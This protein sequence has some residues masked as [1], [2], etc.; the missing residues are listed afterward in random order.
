MITLARVLAAV[1]VTLWGAAAASLPGRHFL[2]LT[3]YR[4]ASALEVELS[5]TVPL[6]RALSE[7][8]GLEHLVSLSEPNRSVIQVTFGQSTPAGKLRTALQRVPSLPA[9]AAMPMLRVLDQRLWLYVLS[10]PSDPA[11]QGRCQPEQVRE[12]LLRQPKIDEVVLI[13]G[14]QRRIEIALDSH[15]L[16]A[17]GLSQWQVAQAIK[18]ASLSLPAG[19]VRD[20]KGEYLIRI[21][22]RRPSIADLQETPI[23]ARP[24]GMVVLLQDLAVI[25][26]TGG[27]M[28]R[29][30]LLVSVQRQATLVSLFRGQ[31]DPTPIVRRIVRR[32][33][34]SCQLRPVTRQGLLPVPTS[35]RPPPAIRQ[36]VRSVPEQWWTEHPDPTMAYYHWLFTRGGSG[37]TLSGPDLAV[38]QR[39]A[40][41]AAALLHKQGLPLQSWAGHKPSITIKPDWKRLAQ[42]GLTVSEVA[43][44]IRAATMATEVGRYQ[45]G[46]REIVV[47]LK[48]THTLDRPEQL[49]SLPI[50]HGG[51]T[52][53]LRQLA[54]LRLV[55]EPIRV[56]RTDRRRTLRLVPSATTNRSTLKQQLRTLAEQLK[57]PPGYAI[58]LGW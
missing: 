23:L 18:R 2:V 17:F 24:N 31:P 16:A 46:T 7:L 15:R 39:L 49:Q 4:G 56:V 30:L 47:E 42:L 58:S 14:P 35:E 19:S 25:R 34:G 13:G 22:Q 51:R 43:N 48:P 37:L 1:F 54:T 3:K 45:H 21:R 29:G 11:L 55:R 33:G 50:I 44:Q 27:F 9:D 5:V 53:S 20:K 10:T 32:H 57:L 28:T 40:N 12:S 6:E 26:E 52:I 36:A 8:V 41:R 38:L